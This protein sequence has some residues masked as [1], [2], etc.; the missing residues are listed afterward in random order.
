MHDG[1]TIGYRSGEAAIQ[2]S[3]AC[4]ARSSDKK[5]I[6]TESAF[7]GRLERGFR[8]HIESRQRMVITQWESGI[9]TRIQ[10][11]KFIH[12]LL[13]LT[14]QS[15]ISGFGLRLMNNFGLPIRNG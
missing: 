6:S 8:T 12:N 13:S 4:R 15:F 1:R 10:R 7:Q 3:L 5:M 2:D 14:L 11:A 9:E